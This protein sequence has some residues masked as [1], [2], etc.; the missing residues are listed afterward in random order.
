MSTIKQTENNNLPPAS[1]VHKGAIYETKKN[2]YE[3]NSNNANQQHTKK[4]NNKSIKSL[5]EFFVSSMV[6]TT[7]KQKTKKENKNK[8]TKKNK[9][10]IEQKKMILQY[11]QTTPL[12]PFSTRI[13]TPK[14]ILTITAYT[15]LP[16]TTQ[17]QTTIRNA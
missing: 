2:N 12:L 15:V 8:K 1:H 7:P 17:P 9:T 13:Q 3:H 14:K 10:K 11:I 5:S 16:T 4:H 6:P